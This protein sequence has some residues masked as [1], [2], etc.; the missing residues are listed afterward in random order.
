MVLMLA[1]SSLIRDSRSATSVLAVACVSSSWVTTISCSERGGGRGIR[2]AESWTE[3]EKEKQQQ[4]NNNNNNNNNK[5]RS[6]KGAGVGRK[7]KGR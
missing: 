6:R 2:T 7:N 4:N 3:G 1:T 5:W